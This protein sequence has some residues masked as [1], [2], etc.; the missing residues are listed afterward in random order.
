M[1]NCE[2]LIAACAGVADTV[3]R[4]CPDVVVLATS[5]EPLRIEGEVA[6]RVPSLSLPEAQDPVAIETLA[7]YDAVHLFVDRAVRVRPNFS[8]T[9]ENAPAVTQICQRL[10]GIPLAIEL[11]SAMVRMMPPEQIASGL[12]DRF[13]VLGA[14]PRT[15]MPRHQT[16]RASV[17][18]SFDLLSEPERVLL[19]RLSV[20]AGGFTL[21]AAETVCGVTPVDAYAILPTLSSLADKSLVLVDEDGATARYRTLETIKQYGAEQLSAADEEPNVRDRHVDFYASFAERLEPGI[22]TDQRNVVSQIMSELDNMRAAMDWCLSAGRID[23][24]CRLCAALDLFWYVAGYL[25]EAGRRYGEFASAAAG[26]SSVAVARV[27]FTVGF[28]EFIKGGTETGRRAMEES[29]AMARETGDIMT[30]GR[31]LYLLG[32][33]ALGTDPVV[34]RPL[35]EEGLVLAEQANDLFILGDANQAFGLLDLIQGRPASARERFDRTCE[36]AG[37][38]G[39]TIHVCEGAIT[40]G[41]ARVLLGEYDEAERLVAEG[42]AI[43]RELGNLYFEANGLAT[44]SMSTLARGDVDRALALALESCDMEIRSGAPSQLPGLWFLGMVYLTR[45]DLKDALAACR[46]ATDPS[47]TMWVWS[48]LPLI[49]ASLGELHLELGDAQAARDVLEE[50]LTNADK[51]QS[52]Y[53]RARVLYVNARLERERGADERAESML[54]EALR[55]QVEAA[56]G[57][58]VC[59]TLEAIAGIAAAQESGAEAARLFGAAQA[60]RDLMGYAHWPLRQASYD[61]D[62]ALLSGQFDEAWA[63]GAAMSMDEAIAYAARGRGERKRPSSGWASLTPMETEVVKLAAQGL[64][65]PQIA[66]KLFISRHT[67]KVHVSHVFGKLG[68]SSRAELASE[69]TRRGL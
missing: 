2:H 7:A 54:H 53:A 14:G 21:E 6:W 41:Y 42:L 49:S 33:D 37:R 12:D 46:A 34:A 67:V 11:A 62:V 64:S 15:A 24:G 13:R 61:E 59:D 28:M 38:A 3:L 1:D 58:G 55:L 29:L 16:L 17:D 60:L 5:R 35:L 50:G 20:F 19:R 25:T 4:T 45:G 32:Y 23:S 31:T 47:R 30:E 69:A 10:E 9:N 44:L 27:L 65:N 57:P 63:E 68:I 48:W 36:E 26:S 56:D 39:D 40:A 51:I 66:E 52:G 22:A 8:V 18:W 43:A